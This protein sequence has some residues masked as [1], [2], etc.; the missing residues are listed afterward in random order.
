MGSMAMEDMATDEMATDE[1]ATDETAM[2]E[3]AMDAIAPQGDVLGAMDAVAIGEKIGAGDI[4]AVEAISAAIA[5]LQRVEPRLNAVAC[6]CFEQALAQAGKVSAE[7]RRLPLSGVPFA[8]K[9]NT[10]LAGLPTRFGSRATPDQVATSDDDITRCFLAT[11]LIP[12]AKTA[13]PEFGLTATTERSHG[14]PTRNPWHTTYSTGG[15]SGGAAALVAAGVVPVAHANDGGG[16]IRIPAACCG[17]VGL[18]PSRDRL[19]T[20]AVADKLPINLLAE[21][22]VSRSV[23]D[24]AAFYAEAERLY[25][26]PALP[27]IGD[28]RSAGRQRLRIGLCTEHPAGGQCDPEVVATVERVARVCETLGHRLEQIS[29]PAAS[30]MADDFLLYWARLAAVLRYTGRF[31]FGRDFDRRQLEPLTEQLSRHYLARFWRG[32]RAIA[33]L[34]QFA[35]HYR[36]Q[37]DHYDLLLT[38]VLATPPVELGYLGPELDFATVSER[39]RHYAAFTP[40]QNVAGTPAVSLPLGR[41]SVGLP[42]GVQFAAAMG[43][44]RRLLEI[45]YELE[46]ACPWSY[47]GAT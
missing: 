42:I 41:S 36:S 27:A 39:L 47:P 6:N 45:A 2:E 23:R 18:K 40:S 22:I 38:P 32:P 8:I 44:E 14:P 21:G 1:T 28:V 24:T 25:P 30:Q 7:Q 3:T 26:N 5:R 13:L 34:R 35:A 33:R 31:A 4:S 29:A 15:S 9:D 20:Q 43:Q 19:P 46:Q 37:F 11:G 17:V 12:I 10:G 16:S